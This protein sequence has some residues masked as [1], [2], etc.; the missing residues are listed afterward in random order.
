MNLNNFEFDGR[1]TQEQ[2]IRLE[3]WHTRQI[4]ELWDRAWE[5]D[6]AFRASMEAMNRADMFDDY[7]DNFEYR[8]AGNAAAWA[9][10]GFS[11]EEW[12]DGLPSNKGIQ[13]NLQDNGILAS[14]TY[15]RLAK[16]IAVLKFF[17]LWPW[18]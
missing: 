12:F 11:E 13:F 10:D 3:E 4:D 1:M 15:R 14:E 6:P 17:D 9:A 18:P 7:I 2:K 16:S 8:L 5:N